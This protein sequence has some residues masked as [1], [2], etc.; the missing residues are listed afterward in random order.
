MREDWEREAHLGG[1]LGSSR[2]GSQRITRGGET[3]RLE[4]CRGP[5]K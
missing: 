2:G 5:E 4:D 1:G 3:P